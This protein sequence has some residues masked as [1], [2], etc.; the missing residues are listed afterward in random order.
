MKWYPNM[1]P[2]HKHPYALL[3]LILLLIS[4]GCDIVVEQLETECVNCHTDK[5]LL[6]EIADPIETPEGTG[7]G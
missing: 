3:L 1:N 2:T 6:K 5:D 4:A 7:E